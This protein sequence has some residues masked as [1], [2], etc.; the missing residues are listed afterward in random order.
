M[1]IGRLLLRSVQRISGRIPALL[2][3]PELGLYLLRS[4]VNRQY[5]VDDELVKQ[6]NTYANNDWCHRGQR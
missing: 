6:E 4:P 5:E 2:H 3:V 1:G